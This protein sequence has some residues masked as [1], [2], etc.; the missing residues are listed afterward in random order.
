MKDVDDDDT[1]NRLYEIKEDRPAVRA[2]YSNLMGFVDQADLEIALTLPS[3]KK[4]HWTTA[5]LMWLLTAL[6]H[7]NAKR[8]YESSTGELSLT[9]REWQEMTAKALSTSSEPTKPAGHGLFKSSRYCYRNCK[10]CLKR[11]V[12]NKK[13]K[14]VSKCLKTA[15]TCGICGP[16]CQSCEKRGDHEVY[17]RLTKK[18]ITAHNKKA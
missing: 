7:V 5:H 10:M 2:A 12:K 18:M 16:M 8:I 3:V 15:W 17:S 13:G 11:R 6:V 4:F 1:Q 9:V 14:M